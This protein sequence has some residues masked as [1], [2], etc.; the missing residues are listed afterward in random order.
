[1]RLHAS[2]LASC[3]A[4]RIRDELVRILA[5]ERPDTWLRLLEDLALL[6]IVLPELD[7]LRGV[8]Q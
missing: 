3:S 2:A 6:P 8:S 5:C 4:E 7:A 1:M